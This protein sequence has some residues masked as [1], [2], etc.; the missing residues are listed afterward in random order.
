MYDFTTLVDRTDTG[1][2]KWD[3]MKRLCPDVPAGIVP[4]S[5]ADME[6]KIAP[7]IVDGL[8]DYLDKTILGYT[9]PTQAYYDAVIH[10]MERRHGY[11]PRQEWFV[12]SPGVVPAIRMLISVF[13]GKDDASLLTPPVY[14]EFQA[15][16]D[17]NDRKTVNSELLRLDDHYEIDFDDF[18]KKAARPDVKVYVLCNPANPVGRIW[19][20][21]ELERI[22]DICLRNDVFIIDDEIHS[23][24][25]M[26]GEEFYSMA[27]L[28][29]K[30]LM[31]CAICTAPSKT[32]NLAGFETSN[33]FV[34]NPEHRKAIRAGHG[35]KSLNILGYKACE[36]AYNKSEA[37]LDELIPLIAANRDY[38]TGFLKENIPGARVYPMQATY[39][40]WVDFRFLGMT[41]K[42]LEEFMTQKAHLFLDEGYIFGE[43][44]EGFER[45]NLACPK[46]VLE[47]AMKRLKAAVDSL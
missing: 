5:V 2:Y 27:L 33:I 22:A 16:V 13:S 4:L 47:D 6:L 46:W 29:E 7:E 36:L 40:L 25:I 12:T 15:S 41:P 14:G 45:I 34:P 30:Y 3:E 8:K 44:G 23:D 38:V 19:T 20:K 28:P 42:E 21:E 32:F 26:P 17:Y 43:G 39:L 24:L 31:N 1:S 10:W 18:E 9:G 37:W 35:Y 11:S